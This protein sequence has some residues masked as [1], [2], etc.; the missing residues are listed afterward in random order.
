MHIQS[1]GDVGQ[2]EGRLLTAIGK[3]GI[4]VNGRTFQ[5]L[6]STTMRYAHYKCR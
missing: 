2:A 5:T 3:L 1:E 4:V 6:V